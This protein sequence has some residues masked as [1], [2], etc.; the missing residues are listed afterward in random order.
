MRGRRGRAATTS[1]AV[2]LA[3]LGF[4][5][6]GCGGGDEEATVVTDDATVK[7]DPNEGDGTIKIESS[8]GS[9]TI[10]GEGGELPEGWPA[11]VQVPAGGTVTSAA[12]MDSDD[13][14][15]WTASLTYADKSSDDLAAEVRS[16]LESAGFTLQGEFTSGDGAMGTYS[17]NGY[18]VTAMV[19][20][21]DG[22]ATLLLTVAKQS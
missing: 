20:E 14:Q 3:L 5:L 4:G 21:E 13:Q 19:G 8:E 18:A 7:I 6:G 16:T 11:E 10:T 9:M 22:A 1:A 17:G 2:A 12:A 15:G